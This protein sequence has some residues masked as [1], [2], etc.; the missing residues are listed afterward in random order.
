MTVSIQELEYTDVTTGVASGDGPGREYPALSSESQ[1]AV[2]DDLAEEF[3]RDVL[4]S[5]LGPLWD[6]KRSSYGN[7]AKTHELLYRKQFDVDAP[8][9]NG[10]LCS[11]SPTDT[12]REIAQRLSD[13]SR[14]FLRDVYGKELTVFRGVTRGA[15]PFLAELLAQPERDAHPIST[16]AVT[17]FTTDVRV[18]TE[19]GLF[20]LE[21]T[22]D[23]E[24]V[25]LAPDFVLKCT[26]NGEV[27]FRD[28]ELRVRGDRFDSVDRNAALFPSTLEPIYRAIQFPETLT[29]AEHEEFATLVRELANRD[30]AITDRRGEAELWEWFDAMQQVH[31]IERFEMVNEVDRS[32]RALCA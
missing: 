19:Y 28:A 15:P 7:Y 2:L 20:V 22:V 8:L 31:G 32:I 24:D 26:R 9:R 4:N 6:W 10:D 30:A 5:V 18:A 14:A 29:P 27:V 1:S 17:N 16:T 11:V 23:V 12:Q 13:L 21:Q 25:L 3:G